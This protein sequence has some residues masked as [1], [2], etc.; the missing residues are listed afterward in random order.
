MNTVATRHMSQLVHQNV[1]LTIRRPVAKRLRHDDHRSKDAQQHWNSIVF[2]NPDARIAADSKEFTCCIQRGRI[3]RGLQ[4]RQPGNLS[5]GPKMSQTEPGAD[6]EESDG[7]YDGE[8]LAKF[9]SR[10]SD[11]G[12]DAGCRTATIDNFLWRDSLLLNSNIR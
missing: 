4:P 7:P 11:D 1:P 3:L 6:G 5:P 10:R 2:P 12:Q 9:P 8:N